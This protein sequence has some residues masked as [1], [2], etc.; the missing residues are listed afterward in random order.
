MRIIEELL[1]HDLYGLVW[2]VIQDYAAA[3]TMRYSGGDDDRS[4][5]ARVHSFQSE[6]SVDVAQSRL[7]RAFATQRGSRS[8]VETFIRNVD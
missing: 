7:P 8:R 1:G 2:K 3:P 6:N 5:M 4:A